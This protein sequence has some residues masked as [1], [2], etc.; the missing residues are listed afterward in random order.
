MKKELPFILLGSGVLLL[1]GA[2]FLAW[3]TELPGGS[4]NVGVDI[5]QAVAEL[6]LTQTQSGP[7]GID[8]IKKLHGIDFPLV[9][10]IVAEYGQK[11]ATLWVA[12]TGSEA[13]ATVLIQQMTE[14]IGAGGLP[15]IPKGVYQFKNRDVYAMDGANGQ[16]NYY[17][18]SGSKVFWMAIGNDKAEQSMKELLAFY[19]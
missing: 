11:Q 16:M 19:P 1:V 2:I 6:S 3:H 9:S 17:I 18:Q 10:G 13:Q 7:A 12:D 14:K 4:V 8:A 5:P 15:F